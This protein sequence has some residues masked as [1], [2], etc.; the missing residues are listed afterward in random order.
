MEKSLVDTKPND[1]SAEPC[2][3]YENLP[4]HGLQNPPTKVRAI[5]LRAVGPPTILPFTVTLLTLIAVVTLLVLA[6]CLG[7]RY[8]LSPSLVLIIVF[9]FF[10]RLPPPTPNLIH[11]L[12]SFLFFSCQPPSLQNR[13]PLA[14]RSILST[15]FNPIAVIVFVNVLLCCLAENCFFIIH[16]F[17][18]RLPWLWPPL[19]A[20]SSIESKKVGAASLA[21]SGATMINATR[22]KSSP[23]KRRLNLCNFHT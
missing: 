20:Y 18:H 9:V 16:F 10:R 2:E 5:C 19:R 3:N 15:D 1:P 12:T 22:T 11:S 21:C 7:C 4:F 14:R 17:P 8:L 23:P 6:P 13:S